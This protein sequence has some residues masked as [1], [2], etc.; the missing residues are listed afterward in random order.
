MQTPVCQTG[1]RVCAKTFGVTLISDRTVLTS[2]DFFTMLYWYTFVAWAGCSRVLA[3][4]FHAD[5]AAA[6]NKPTYLRDPR[7]SFSELEEVSLPVLSWPVLQ[8]SFTTPPDCGESSYRGSNRLAGRRALIT[9]GDS[10]IGRAISIAFAREGAHVA[11]NYLPGE[12]E[13][14]QA[15][16]DFLSMEG[17]LLEKIPG[18]LLNETFCT[19]L[20]HQAIKTLGGLDLIVNN[21]GYVSLEFYRRRT[22]LT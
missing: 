1:I 5:V 17:L 8:S 18:D 21:A 2:R 11:I 10:G 16:S 13:D 22:M 7:L 15:L 19:D 3:S 9:G 12:E 14:A 20:V 4:T 6:N